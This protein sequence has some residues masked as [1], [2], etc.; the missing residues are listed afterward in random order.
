M[1]HI[2]CLMTGIYFFNAP[3]AVDGK[4]VFTDKKCN[5]CHTIESQSIPLL[6]KDDDDDDDDDKEPK[7]LSKVGAE[8]DAATIKQFLQRSIELNEKKHK[9]K[10]SGSDEELDAVANWLASLK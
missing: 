7:D 2:I 4:A 10:F 5:K 9:K 8:V 6:P 1:L 3:F